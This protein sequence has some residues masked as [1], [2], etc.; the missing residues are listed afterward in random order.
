MIVIIGTRK[1]IWRKIIS[2]LAILLVLGWL[3]MAGVHF[4]THPVPTPVFNGFTDDKIPTGNPLRVNNDA[5][6]DF[7]RS[8]EQFVIK[9]QDFYYE[10]RE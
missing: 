10:E 4:V 3:V 7:D 8:V 5:P 1:Q 6:S 2:G 9:L